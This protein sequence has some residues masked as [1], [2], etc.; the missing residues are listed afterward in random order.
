MID[1]N[2][3]IGKYLY[4]DQSTYPV[5][6]FNVQSYDKDEGLVY[7]EQVL[8]SDNSDDIEVYNGPEWEVNPKRDKILKVC[9]TPE[10][11]FETVVDYL[12]DQIE[13]CSG[14]IINTKP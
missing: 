10:E 5:W 4:I 1:Y 6:L 11:L 9:D 14:L 13:A 12:R 2:Q 7:S 8:N 3:Y